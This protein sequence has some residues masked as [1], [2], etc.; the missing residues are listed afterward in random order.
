MADQFVSHILDV[1]F[2]VGEVESTRFFGGTAIKLGGVQF[3][4][5]MRGVLY[6][7][8][9]DPLR[10]RFREMGGSLS[11]IR[12]K[13]VRR[14]FSAITQCR[15]SCWRRRNSCVLRQTARLPTH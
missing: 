2:D 10:E 13:R 5:I 6:F 12:Q 3:A 15:Q 14:Q 4:M 11:V 8:V 1:L 7:V 9:D